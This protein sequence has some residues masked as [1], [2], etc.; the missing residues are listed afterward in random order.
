MGTKISA[1]TE[2]TSPTASDMMVVV[3]GGATKKVQIQ[4]V[5]K[6]APAIWARVYHN[7]SQSIT[8]A[9]TTALAF[10]SE[11]ADTNT[12]HDTVTNNSRLTCQTAGVY[13]ITASVQF[14]ANATGFRQV[15]IRL[16]GTTALAFQRTPSPGGSDAALLTISTAY[17]LSAADYVEATVYQNSGGSLNVDTSANFT[18]EF[19]MVRLGA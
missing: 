15:G 13:Y 5:A 3:N 19:M 14:A 18:P 1:L 6:P 11:R 7:A 4:N 12:I 2:V 16:N 10:N 8:T 9:T 17:A